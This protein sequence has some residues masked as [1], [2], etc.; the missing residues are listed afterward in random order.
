MD[1]DTGGLIWCY[2]TKGSVQSSPAV[3]N[4]KVFV[5]SMDYNI[6]CLDGDNGDLIWSYGTGG[7]M[8]S[9]P[10]VADGKVFV[11]NALL[12]C[13]KIYCFEATPELT[14]PPTPTP[15]PA[16]P[17]VHNSNTGESFSTIQDAIDDVDTLDGH[18]ITVDPGTYTENVDVY[19]SLTIK[20]TSGNPA[21]TIV[22]AKNSDDHVFEVTTDY[23]TISGFKVEG[24][25][26]DLRY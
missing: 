19:K 10:A 12:M 23:V 9:S 26:G 15:E 21:D 13:G 3:A 2:E 22:H 24:G 7:S 25:T 20:S 14:P 16:A 1:A 6:Y 17:S 18:T 4:G 8:Y 11:G 5:G